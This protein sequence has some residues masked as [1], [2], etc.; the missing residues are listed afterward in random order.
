MYG[1]SHV[2]DKTAGETVLFLTWESLYWSKTASLYWDGP[3]I[4]F[5]DVKLGRQVTEAVKFFYYKMHNF[6]QIT[7]HLGYHIA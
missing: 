3:Q 5:S 1:D 4:L 6:T 7:F 2:K